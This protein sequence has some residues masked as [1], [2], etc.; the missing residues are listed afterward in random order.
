MNPAVFITPLGEISISGQIE[1]MFIEDEIELKFVVDG[2]TDELVS[3]VNSQLELKKRA[4]FEKCKEYFYTLGFCSYEN[5]IK[6]V[7]ELDIIAQTLNIKIDKGK[8]LHTELWIGAIDK[9]AQLIE[10]DVSIPIDM[11]PYKSEIQKIIVSSV[12]NRFFN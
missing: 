3:I 8:L 12:V 2:F 5:L 11:K 9:I 10:C 7:G 4:I 1:T 6:E